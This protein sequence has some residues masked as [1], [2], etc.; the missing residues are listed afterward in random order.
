MKKLEK[1]K[2]IFK[3]CKYVCLDMVF[4]IYKE[5]REH[6]ST[7]VHSLKIIVIYACVCVCVGRNENK[8]SCDW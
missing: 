4:T 6:V 3:V 8:A 2:K 5:E 7:H 1:K